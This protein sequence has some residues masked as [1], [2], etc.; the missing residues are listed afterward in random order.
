MY[1]SFTVTVPITKSIK[2]F[3]TRIC[4]YR[5]VLVSFLEKVIK[6]DR[7]II[8]VMSRSA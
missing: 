5:D 8:L 6:I 4:S 7:L 2:Y 1:L 3:L